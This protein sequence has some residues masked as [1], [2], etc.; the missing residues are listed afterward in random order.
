MI[1]VSN[2][3]HLKKNSLDPGDKVSEAMTK[4]AQTDNKSKTSPMAQSELVDKISQRTG[5]SP[6][7]IQSIL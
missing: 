4:A 5:A 3:Y 6:K 1:N 2:F 7:D